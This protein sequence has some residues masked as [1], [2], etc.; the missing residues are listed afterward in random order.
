MDRRTLLKLG[1]SAVALSALGIG[2]WIQWRRMSDRRVSE[3]ITGPWAELGPSAW[4]LLPDLDHA[5]MVVP[6]R[7]HRVQEARDPALRAKIHRTR[8][9]H[10]SSGPKRIRGAD[11]ESSPKPG[12]FRILAV[13]DSIT[14][15]WGVEDD[16]SWPYQLGVELRR[17]GHPVEVINAGVPAN[18]IDTMASWLVRM[19]PS[20]GASGVLFCRRPDF[21]RPSPFEGYAR[22]VLDSQAALPGARFHVLLPPVSR[23]DPFGTISAPTEQRQLAEQLPATPVLDLTTAFRDT[24]GPHGCTLVQGGGRMKVVRMETNETLLDAPAAEHDLPQEIYALFERDASVR[25]ALFFDSGHPDATGQ[26]LFAR[27]VADAVEGQGWF[28]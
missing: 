14:F 12:T 6:D 26:E 15:G 28:G 21:Q 7:P 3:R 27:V 25:E 9:F 23:F 5:L 10:V 13:G 1:S 22:A 2:G 17:R 24:Q 8:S 4:W 18:P 20:Y 11:F 19:A 16:E